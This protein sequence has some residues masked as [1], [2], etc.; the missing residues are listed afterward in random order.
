MPHGGEKINC[1]ER[2]LQGGEYKFTPDMLK[3]QHFKSVTLKING[4][5]HTVQMALKKQF[6]KN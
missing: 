3:W 2:S 1:I 5:I 6:R 4:N